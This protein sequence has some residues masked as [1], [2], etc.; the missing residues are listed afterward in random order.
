M[1]KEEELNHIQSM[2]QR[3]CRLMSTK[4]TFTLKELNEAIQDKPATTLR[5]RVYDNIGTLFQR[6]GRGI[7][8]VINECFEFL[9]K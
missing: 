8:A 2:A 5:A 6:V 1:N 4:E 9:S 7:Y 3:I